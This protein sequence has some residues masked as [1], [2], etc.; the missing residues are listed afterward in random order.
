VKSVRAAAIGF[1]LFSS[2]FWALAHYIQNM[3]IDRLAAAPMDTV[4]V[5]I[6]AIS[7]MPVL[8]YAVVCMVVFHWLKRHL[9]KSMLAMPKDQ[10]SV[11]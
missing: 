5:A 6:V 7:L 1:A 3:G 10:N 11:P 8:I 4:G 9:A 2:G